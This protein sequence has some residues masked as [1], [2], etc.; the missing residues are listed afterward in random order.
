VNDRRVASSV[1]NAETG[2]PKDRSDVIALG[3]LISMSSKLS[4]A[5]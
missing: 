4:S 2:S 1:E 5:A 3:N